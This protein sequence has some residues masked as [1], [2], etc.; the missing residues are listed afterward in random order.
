MK[1]FLLLI[2]V[3]NLFIMTG[4]AQVAESAEGIS[5]LLISEKIP[6]MTVRNAKNE[7]VNIL[8]ILKTKP[9]VLVIYR[10][11]WCPYCNVQLS[12][13][14][15]SEEEILKS[16]YQIVA[17]SPESYLNIAPTIENDTINYQVFSDENANLIQK[18]GLAFKPNLKTMSYLEAK[19]KGGVT[20]ILPVPA[21]FIVNTDAEILF[22][23]INPN[24]KK[25]L[26]D[27]V[28]MAVLNTLEK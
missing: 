9:T 2:A 28:L 22:E 4:N 6:D 8:D 20:E 10:G 19:T 18:M 21:V 24:Y 23:Y 7:S 5:P 25:R 12:A 16:G 14:G 11:G 27:E 17:I 3:L 1:K 13:L 15:E 26:T